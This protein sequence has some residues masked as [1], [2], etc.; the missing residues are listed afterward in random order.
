MTRLT[1]WRR[2]GWPCGVAGRGR[3]RATTGGASPAVARPSAPPSARPAQTCPS[4]ARPSMQRRVECVKT[5]KVHSPHS[6]PLCGERT[7]RALSVS[8]KGTLT[9]EISTHATDEAELTSSTPRRCLVRASSLAAATRTCGESELEAQK[10]CARN[11]RFTADS[12]SLCAMKTCKHE[13]MF[14]GGQGLCM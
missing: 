7:L 14:I 6:L 3:R 12:N 5:S 11:T 2:G 1:S 4:P 9:H 13:T 8:E 10:L